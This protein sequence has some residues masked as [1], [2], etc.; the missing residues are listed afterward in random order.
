VKEREVGRSL[1]RRPIA[2]SACVYLEEGGAG[3]ATPPQ[4]PHTHPPTHP[5]PRL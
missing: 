5:P 1:C 3:V 2:D 4:P